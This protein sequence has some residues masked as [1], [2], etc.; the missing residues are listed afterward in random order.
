MKKIVFIFCCFIAFSC[1]S[2]KGVVEAK[3]ETVAK[4]KVVVAKVK[5]EVQKKVTAMKDASGNLVGYADKESFN[6]IPY[7][8]WF[9]SNH[10]A[11]NTDS[12][13]I[14]KIKEPIKALKVRAFMGTWCGDSK[15]E[16]P[17]FYKVL[18]EADFNFD[19]LELITLN[20]SKRTPDNLQQG[21][22]VIRVP[23]FIFYKDGKEIGRYVEYP[24]ETLEKD[25]LKIVTQQPYKHS[26]DR[27]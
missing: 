15:R 22:N 6:Q 12:E 4:E 11:Y 24:R 10:K 17:R 2:K 3:K 26:Y 9:K 13:T 1:S 23:T 7:S 25:I 8:A 14:A 16:T 18:E 27:S 20:R 21:H 5:E 19:N